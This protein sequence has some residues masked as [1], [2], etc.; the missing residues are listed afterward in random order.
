MFLGAVVSYPSTKHS[1]VKDHFQPEE[2]PHL[3]FKVEDR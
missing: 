1:A 2:Y 3:S